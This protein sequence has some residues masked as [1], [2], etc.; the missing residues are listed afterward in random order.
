MIRQFYNSMVTEAAAL[1]EPRLFD[2][3]LDGLEKGEK[4]VKKVLTK[5]AGFGNLIELS[6]RW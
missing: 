3:I 6:A 4:S 1:A 2:P 5:G